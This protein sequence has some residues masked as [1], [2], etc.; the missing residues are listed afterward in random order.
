MRLSISQH[1]QQEDRE[2]IRQFHAMLA[3]IYAGAVVS[4]GTW[5]VIQKNRPEKEQAIRQFAEF[6][7]RL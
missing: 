5:W 3:A 1:M 6:I 7:Y 4:C 2:N